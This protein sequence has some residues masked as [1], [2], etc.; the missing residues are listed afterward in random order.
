V[1]GQWPALGLILDQRL[2][3][4]W[5]TPALARFSGARVGMRAGTS[6]KLPWATMRRY[7]GAV[8][9]CLETGLPVTWVEP[10][11]GDRVLPALGQ[12]FPLPMKRG[13]VATFSPLP[14]EATS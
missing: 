4:T 6:P 3:I 11:D 8:E 14:D 2:R 9:R 10:G 5:I 7:L 12:A 1:A 13:V